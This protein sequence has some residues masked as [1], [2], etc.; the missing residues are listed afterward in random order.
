M[1]W[2]ETQPF[3]SFT[4][5]CSNPNASSEFKLSKKFDKKSLLNGK[6]T[7]SL[8]NGKSDSLK[9]GKCLKTAIWPGSLT[10]IDTNFKDGIPYGLTRLSFVNDSYMDINLNKHG[11][12]HGIKKII[13]YK[14]VAEKIQHSE[15]FNTFM[16][17]MIS[18]KILIL[19]SSSLSRHFQYFMNK[20][21]LTFIGI[22]QQKTIYFI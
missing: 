12:M 9:I 15:V 11:M 22:D 5:D 21:N 8:H 4:S 18:Y 20:K 10:L 16:I 17:L 6:V 1:V 3:L 19:Q 13:N 7:I 14:R 2:A